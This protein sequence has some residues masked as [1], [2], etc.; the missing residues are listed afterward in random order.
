MQNKINEERE[1]SMR[2]ERVIP[3]AF[4]GS[5]KRKEQKD[6]LAS[7]VGK[8]YVKT[9][10]VMMIGFLLV[11]CGVVDSVSPSSDEN[12]QTTPNG[13]GETPSDDHSH[14][15]NHDG[16]YASGDHSHAHNHD[17]NYAS[18]D[19]S[20]DHN[21]DGD[22]ASDDHPHDHSHDE[23]V[24]ITTNGISLPVKDVNFDH[25]GNAYEGRLVSNHTITLNSIPYILKS[26][27]MVSLG[28]SNF[29]WLSGTLASNHAVTMN[30]NTHTFTFASNTQIIFFPKWESE[31]RLPCQQSYSNN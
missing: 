17:G 20:H 28:G 11:G 12:K 23:I 3:F 26:N 25:L 30:S 2:K 14:A 4:L 19:H 7:E 31:C 22:Y 16:N 10:V 24:T 27:T 5:Q 8:I 9:I 21:H 1:N 29:R 15:H 6:R 13:N 18:D